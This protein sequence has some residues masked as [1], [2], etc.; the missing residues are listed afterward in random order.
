MPPCT[1]S[2]VKSNQ[3][4]KF[5]LLNI[6]DDFATIKFNFTSALEVKTH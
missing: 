5:K 4:L 2:N 1:H 3:V 6:V